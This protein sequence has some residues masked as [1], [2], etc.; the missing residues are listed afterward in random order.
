[1]DCQKILIAA[2]AWWDT[3]LALVGELDSKY[4]V[5][6][7]ANNW[8]SRV[9]DDYKKGSSKF[10]EEQ[11]NARYAKRN[12]TLLQGSIRTRILEYVI[13]IIIDEAREQVVPH[14][15]QKYALHL[16]IWPYALDKE[17]CELIEGAISELAPFIDEVK[18]VNVSMKNLT[19]LYIKANKYIMNIMYDLEEW[20]QLHMQSLAEIKMPT[21]YL[22]CPDILLVEDWKSQ[23]TKD[24]LAELKEYGN[25]TPTLGL[26]FCTTEFY[27]IRRIPAGWFSAVISEA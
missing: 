21:Q 15:H 16:N 13:D 26:E 25:W 4:A 9:T 3:R 23:L 7:L 12:F 6:L 11:F 22:I 8:P 18:C 17:D 10:T 24:E 19:P 2:D 14:S 27:P 1:M 5:K 20:L